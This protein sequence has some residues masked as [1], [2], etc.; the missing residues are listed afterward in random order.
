[1]KRRKLPRFGAFGLI[2]LLGP[3]SV[4]LLAAACAEFHLRE[5]APTNGTAGA[6]GP[7]VPG[8][9]S[10]GC[11]IPAGECDQASGCRASCLDI[12]QKS[13]TMPSGDYTIDIDGPG[14]L[15][16]VQVY[17]DMVTDGGGWTRFWWSLDDS[18]DVSLDPLGE[19]LWSCDPERSRC[20]GKIPVEVR[21]ADFMVKDVNE[22]HWAAWHFDDKNP[23]SNAALGAMRNHELACALDTGVNW[24]P[25]ATNDDSGEQWCGVGGEEGGCDSF[26]Y[27]HDGSC[28]AWKTGGWGL[29]LDGD[30]GCYA[31]ALKV[32]VAQEAFLP[33][34]GGPDNNFLDDGPTEDDQSGELYY[35]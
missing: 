21:P 35:R 24:M 33:E 11:A 5:D 13:P 23:V 8:S 19:D 22:G 3:L 30:G 9:T 17:C 20:F 7:C 27:Q 34:C 1:M 6:G 10:E 32:S 12:H 18:G 28:I 16:P 29:E 2:H 4:A 26:Q 25:Y 31:A 15:A 14:G